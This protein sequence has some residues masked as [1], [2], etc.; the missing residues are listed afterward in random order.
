[1]NGEGPA[2]PTAAAAVPT[3]AQGMSDRLDWDEFLSR[4][5][6]FLSQQIMHSMGEGVEQPSSPSKPILSS[7]SAK[8]MQRKEMVRMAYVSITG[9]QHKELVC[10]A[11]STR[12]WCV[13]HVFQ[14]QACTA[15]RWC[16]WHAP[17]GDGACGMCF[18]HRHA[19][20]ELVCVACSTR[21]W[22]AWHVFQPQACTA[23]SWC[24]ACSAKSWCV[25]HA[26]CPHAQPASEFGM[27]NS[28]L[29]YAHAAPP[30]NSIFC[31]R[32]C[33]LTR[34]RVR[35]MCHPTSAPS[36]QAKESQAH[37]PGA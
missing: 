12:R 16:V 15:R 6:A 23:R 25:W 22:C 14:P 35:V 17:Q 11:C 26:S 4:Q 13:Q 36:H 24:V 8:I 34:R 20:K 10:V 19:R 21:R 7:G 3:A 37:A 18:K 33:P 5:Y 30:H 9:M 27:G 32:G 28:G 1:M 31:T 29:K 2:A